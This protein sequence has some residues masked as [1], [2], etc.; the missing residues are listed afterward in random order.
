MGI[1]YTE[2]NK[3]LNSITNLE[4]QLSNA[5]RICNT[6]VEQIKKKKEEVKKAYQF[7]ASQER[8]K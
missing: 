6:E 2:F 7:L 3:L 1:D 5:I 8:V 4:A